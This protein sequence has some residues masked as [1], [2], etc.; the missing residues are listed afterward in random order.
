MT[1]IANE[2]SFREVRKSYGIRE[3]L[4]GFTGTFRAGRV[5]ALVGPN[6]AGKTTLLRIAAGLQRMDSGAIFTAGTLYYGGS[7]SLPVSSTV[8][9]LRKTL[10][11]RPVPH[12]DRHMRKLSK[13][14]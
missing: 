1:I 6:G 4:R 11:L 5:T 13:G 7:D 14:E 8:N 9:R 12:G 10:G 2:I 3:V